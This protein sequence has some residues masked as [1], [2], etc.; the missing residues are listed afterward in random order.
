VQVTEP[1]KLVKTKYL[2]VTGQARSLPFAMALVVEQN[3]IHDF[4]TQLANS[5]LRVQITQ[6]SLHHVRD[7]SSQSET[8]AGGLN[9]MGP[10]TG[11]G[12]ERPE[13]P[14]GGLGGPRGT[15]GNTG[16]VAAEAPDPNLVEVTVYGIAT[17]Y[18]KFPLKKEEPKADP[19]NP[20]PAPPVPMN[21]MSK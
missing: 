5:Q 13:R 21:P 17:L 11:P 1:N 8:P 14:M 16:A 7:V 6:V 3:H 4:L 18:E 19:M 10:M 20:M 2:H 12:P 15:G 9:P